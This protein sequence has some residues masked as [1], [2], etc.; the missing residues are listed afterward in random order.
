MCLPVIALE[1]FQL[2]CSLESLP[3]LT[4]FSSPNLPGS[5]NIVEVSLKEPDD[6]SSIDESSI[7]GSSIHGLEMRSGLG[8]TPTRF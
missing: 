8:N 4:G 3:E 2:I 6:E 5:F 7:D 1:E